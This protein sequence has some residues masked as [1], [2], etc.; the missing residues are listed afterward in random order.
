MTIP[1]QHVFHCSCLKSWTGS[2][3]PVCRHT[4]PDSSD[5]YDPR[6][7]FT[8]P[9]GSH[10]SNLCSICDSTDE[11]WICLICGN[12][13]CGRYKG[14]HAKDHW[15]ETAHCFA[16]ELETQHVWDY[17]GDTWVHR[18]I[19]EKGGGKIL[20]LPASTRPP[21]FG[22][23]D[24]DEDVVPRAKLDSIG[25]EYTHLISSQLESQRA[26]FE[27]M[28]SKAADKAA[29]A[30]ADAEHAALEAESA[31]RRLSE[32]EIKLR[33]LSTDTVPQLERD[34]DRE[35]NK[36]S[37]AQDLARNLGKSLQEEKGVGEGLMKRVEHVNRE[38][39]NL[40]KRITELETQN[41]ELQEMNRDLTMFISGGEKLKQMQAEGQ[42]DEEELEGGSVGVT[43]KRRRR[44]K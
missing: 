7:P 18:L 22:R 11:L 20:E 21:E 32:L 9:F 13:G 34:L 2:G 15:K 44:K 40:A 27:E 5:Q 36:A 33:S 24:F 19:R 10:I 26:Y 42:I 30:M 14:G 39:E 6:N 3:C 4:A 17:A 16:L 29:K 23:Q 1:C 38:K 31:T 12:V 8:Q 25:L 37:K 35:R 41:A 43:E 28:V